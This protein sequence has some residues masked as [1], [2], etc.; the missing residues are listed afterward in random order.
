MANATTSSPS[1]VFSR[2]HFLSAITDKSI[3]GIPSESYGEREHWI[4]ATG[5]VWRRVPGLAVCIR[6][7]IDIENPKR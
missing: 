6:P 4:R 3:F 1:V 5:C 7:R 2:T